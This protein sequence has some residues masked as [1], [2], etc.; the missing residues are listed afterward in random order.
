MPKTPEKLSD[1]WRTYRDLVY[2]K[3]IPANQNK[4]C[5]QAFMSGA[6]AMMMIL[7]QCSE[8]PEG[9]AEEILEERYQEIRQYVDVR[10][11]ELFALKKPHTN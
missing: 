2:P 1:S 11:K 8:F 9:E 6:Y 10:Q 4:E 3:D 7:H 5:H